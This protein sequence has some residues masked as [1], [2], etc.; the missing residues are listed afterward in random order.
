MDF[1]NTQNLILLDIVATNVHE[2]VKDSKITLEGL[3]V[4]CT[5]CYNI[6]C[7]ESAIYIRNNFLVTSVLLYSTS[8]CEVTRIYIW[9]LNIANITLNWPL[10]HTIKI[11]ENTLDRV[12]TPIKLLCNFKQDWFL[13]QVI[14]TPNINSKI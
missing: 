6:I 2:K 5:E 7:S 12:K 14:N 4:Y 11:F 13:A 8:V 10:L 1:V 3:S 9:E